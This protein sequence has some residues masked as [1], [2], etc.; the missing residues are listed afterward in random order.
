MK[1]LQ[2]IFSR[3]RGG[4]EMP[5][6]DWAVEHGR[7]GHQTRVVTLP[8][9]AVA[10]RAR[11]LGLDLD[12][13][14]VWGRFDLA[15]IW[16]L[17][18]LL[19]RRQ[20]DVVH[21]HIPRD[22]FL[23]LPALF[24]AGLQARVVLTLSVG[25]RVNKK[26]ILHRLVYSKVDRVVVLSDLLRRNILATCPLKEEVLR[27]VYPGIDLPAFD[28]AASGDNE[29]EGDPIIG[30][31]SRVSRGKGQDIML[32]ALARIITDFPELRCYMIGGWETEDEPFQ[33]E[34]IALIHELKLDGKA[35]LLGHRGDIGALLAQMDY[36]VFPTTNEAFG[37]S[38]V[39]AMAAG[40]PCLAT[41]HDGPLEIIDGKTNGLFLSLIHI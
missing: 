2:I 31:V 10:A 28:A 30:N 23:I 21:V 41:R 39:E 1:I 32:R 19:R 20:P 17:S 4:R 12:E 8:G 25:N 40:L 3:G 15:A 36:F 16:R 27:I 18:S 6:L 38:L 35:F 5:P 7:H 33:R 29:L 24:F 14:P 34:L 11:E 9:A 26:D 13:L 22:L 37:I